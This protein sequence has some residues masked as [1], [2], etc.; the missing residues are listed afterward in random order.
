MSPM[1]LMLVAAMTAAGPAPKTAPL[2]PL[3][4]RVEAFARSNLGKSVGDGICLTLASEAL[5]EAGARRGSFADPRG[6]FTWGEPVAD[7]KDVLP[8]DILQFRDAVF[9]GKRATGKR[10]W[11]SWHQEYPH[12]TAIV[13]KVEQGGKL[14]TVLHQ[15]VAIQGRDESKKGSVQETELR[16]DSIQKGGW[17]RAYRP[18][19][20]D[21][22]ERRRPFAQAEDPGR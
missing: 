7:F 1:A 17:V 14:V 19:P 18:A 21:P 3:N 10:R 22:S 11:V 4:A 13:S 15:N 20:P 2:P 12:H 5:R 16:M 6:D 8:G 9:L